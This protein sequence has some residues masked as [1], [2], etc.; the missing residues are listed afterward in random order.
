MDETDDKSKQRQ[1][2]IDIIQVLDNLFTHE[3]SQK[4]ECPFLFIIGFKGLS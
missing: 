2:E 4:D 1:N 3:N